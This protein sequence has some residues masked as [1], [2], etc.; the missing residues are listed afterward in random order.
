MM[1]YALEMKK[2]EQF[3]LDIKYSRNC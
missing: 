2:F 3:S 1:L